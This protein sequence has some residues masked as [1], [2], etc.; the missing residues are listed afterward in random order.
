MQPVTNWLICRVEPSSQR[1]NRDCPRT[2]DADARTTAD[3]YEFLTDALP[4]HE[5][6]RVRRAEATMARSSDAQA[7]AAPLS[8][9]IPVLRG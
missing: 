9:A 4:H 3:R 1:H 8:G 2:G 5:L 7:A 6:R